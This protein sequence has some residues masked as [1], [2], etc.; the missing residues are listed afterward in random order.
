MWL[1]PATS[2]QPKSSIRPTLTTHSISCDTYIRSHQPAHM[3][4]DP[5]YY[6]L[7]FIHLTCDRHMWRL[8]TSA[9]T[10]HRNCLRYSETSVPHAIRWLTNRNP[11]DN[12][13]E[14]SDFDLT[15]RSCQRHEK[16]SRIDSFQE[17]AGYDS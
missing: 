10:D 15:A 17:A 14:K 12:S 5:T 7:S 13:G 4:V 2:R 9:F 1:P 8:P 6:L 16:S 3:E 11:L